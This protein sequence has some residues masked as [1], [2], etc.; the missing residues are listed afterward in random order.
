MADEPQ[1][2]VEEPEVDEAEE[3]EIL[4]DVKD[5]VTEDQEGK[6][7][8]DAKA[9]IKERRSVK[10]IKDQLKAVQA[11]NEQITKAIQP[12]APVLQTLQNNPELLQQLQQGHIPQQAPTAPPDPSNAELEEFARTMDLYDAQGRP[13]VQ[14]A[15]ILDERNK[16]QMA[17]LV[18]ERVAPLAQGSANDKSINLFQQMALLK[19]KS[20]RAVQAESLAEM[21]KVVPPDMTAEPNVA[22]FMRWA[23]MGRD[24]DEG[25][26]SDIKPPPPAL[27]TESAGGRGNAPTSLNDSQSKIAREMGV[28]AKDFAAGIDF[29]AKNNG[30]LE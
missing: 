29:V 22:H 2:P 16:R 9:F 8:I 7:K 1:A 24:L 15:A 3:T 5:D 25:K 21:W 26:M 30:R 12:W 11:Q 14:R 6:K 19:G 28:S 10:A 17:Q 27:M 4:E 13:D 20:G 18:D 23:A